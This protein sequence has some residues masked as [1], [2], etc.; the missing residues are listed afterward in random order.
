MLYAFILSAVV[1]GG[2]LLQVSSP[3]DTVPPFKTMLAQWIKQSNLTDAE[4]GQ[5]LGTLLRP[6][7]TRKEVVT[8]LGDP[9]LVESYGGVP[10]YVVIYSYSTYRLDITFDKDGKIVGDK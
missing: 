9:D 5:R 1:G 8:L 2:G 7:M 4:K 10:D 3:D 6:R